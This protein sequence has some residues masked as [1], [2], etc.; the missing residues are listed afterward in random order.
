MYRIE[1]PV[2]KGEDG[3]NAL[4]RDTF[5]S[6]VTGEPDTSHNFKCI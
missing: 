5:L 3:L 6:R 1:Q 2:Y 4:K